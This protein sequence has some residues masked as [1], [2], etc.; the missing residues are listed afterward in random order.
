M[1]LNQSYEFL[2]IEEDWLD[3]LVLVLSGKAE[4]VA[5]YDK[6]VRSARASFRL[7]A[8]V[9]MRHQVTVR[10]RNRLFQVPTKRAVFLR[11]RFECQYCGI[12]ITMNS[13]TR[14]HVHPLSRKGAHS[15]ANVVTACKACNLE[16][17]NRTPEEAG[18][19]LR[20]RPRALSEDEKIR[21]LLRTSRSEER[22]AWLDCM[23]RLGI[24]LWTT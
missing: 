2:N 23:D 12:R 5:E 16:K 14:D 8:V 22:Q 11:D 17:A 6:V 24:N 13:G 20:S 9:I 3:A 19:V 10:R 4:P 15:L 7:P 21:C 1:V 18:M